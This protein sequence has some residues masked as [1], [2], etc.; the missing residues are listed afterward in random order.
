MKNCYFRPVGFGENYIDGKKIT[1]NENIKRTEE[2]EVKI[3]LN[4]IKKPG[5]YF[6]NWRM[7]TQEGIPFGKV[8]YLV[9]YAH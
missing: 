1:I 3:E 5:E 8:F 4:K 9:I 2:I 7:F 6:S